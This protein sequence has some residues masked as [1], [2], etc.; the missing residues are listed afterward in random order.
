VLGYIVEWHAR[1]KDGLPV[2]I[3]EP[4]ADEEERRQLARA[5]QKKYRITQVEFL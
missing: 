4:I 1:I 3:V 2:S 5:L